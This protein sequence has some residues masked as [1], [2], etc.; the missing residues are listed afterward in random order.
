[1]ANLP[2]H[3]NNFHTQH[4]RLPIAHL[5]LPSKPLHIFPQVPE[6]VLGTLDCE[7]G[8]FVRRNET[9]WRV[10]VD[11]AKVVVGGNAIRIGVV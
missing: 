5:I 10:C 2:S 6:R 7:C 11:A 8:V 3:S 9:E 1:M 4:R